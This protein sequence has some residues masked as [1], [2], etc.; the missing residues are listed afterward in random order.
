MVHISTPDF[1]ADEHILAS[2]RSAAGRIDVD[3]FGMLLL[4]IL[5]YQKPE[6]KRRIMYPLTEETIDKRPEEM[7]T[8]KEWFHA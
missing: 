3:I 7:A 4:N 8:A 5:L 6:N 2:Y 1:I